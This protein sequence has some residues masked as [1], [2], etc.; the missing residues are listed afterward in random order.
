MWKKHGKGI[1]KLMN[2]E[3]FEMTMRN[4]RKHKQIKIITVNERRNYLMSEPKY[5]T[6]KC[7]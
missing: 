7:F 3:V 1:F 5:H 4:V 6:I 2:N